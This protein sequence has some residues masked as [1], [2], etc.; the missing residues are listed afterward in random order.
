MVTGVQTCAL[1]ICLGGTTRTVTF[2]LP[3]ALFQA[4]IPGAFGGPWQ[5]S[6][7]IPGKAFADPSMA[8]S[9]IAVIVLFALMFPA[10]LQ[11]PQ[12]VLR[13]ASPGRAHANGAGAR[14]GARQQAHF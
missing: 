3:T 9:I 13:H 8:L 12:R 4:I 7:W 10:A 14:L 2:G 11:R 6:R 5:W 1:P